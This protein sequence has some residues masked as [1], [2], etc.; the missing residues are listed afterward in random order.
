MGSSKRNSDKM[1]DK[2]GI[3]PPGCGRESEPRTKGV[4]KKEHFSLQRETQKRELSE[5]G[6]M[7]NQYF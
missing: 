4:K 7:L 1:E 2:D 6:E 3:G 5:L